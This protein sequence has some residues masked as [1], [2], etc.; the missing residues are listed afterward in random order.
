MAGAL[1]AF[2]GCP[3]GGSL[4]ALEIN[5]RFGVEYFEHVVEVVFAGTVCMVVFRSLAGLPITSFWSITTDRLTTS[6][7]VQILYGA[8]LGGVGAGFA[9]LY[10]QFQGW[11]MHVFQQYH[12]LDKDNAVYRAWAGTAGLVTVGMI[13]PHTLFW[14]E[15]EFQTIATMAPAHALPHLWTAASAGLL[16]FEIHSFGTALTVGLAK[17]LAISFSVAGGYRGGYIFPLFSSGAALGRA[18]YFLLPTGV[19]PVQLC[20]LCVAAGLNVAVTRTSLS[21]PIILAYLSGEPNA[22]SAILAASLVSLFVTAY[23]PFI[24]T[25]VPRED[26]ETSLYHYSSDAVSVKNT[27]H[28]HNHRD[29]NSSGETEALT[30]FSDVHKQMDDDDD[31]VE[32]ISM[33]ARG[34]SYIV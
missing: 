1:A 17:L 29:S 22:L 13:I 24:I 5:S 23:M 12:L 19:V 30:P 9:W 7:P 34:H 26:L 16:N 8:L 14:G 27:N 32:C 15:S 3:L 10:V 6:E 28:D 4:F 25:Q 20:V 21:T 31:E 18:I 2:F 11:L 33:S